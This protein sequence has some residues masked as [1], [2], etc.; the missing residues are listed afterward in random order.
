MSYANHISRTPVASRI[1]PVVV[2]CLHVVVLGAILWGRFLK[3][4]PLKPQPPSMK[5]E[6]V[7][8]K[9]LD[10]PGPVSPPIEIEK[11]K[12]EIEKPKAEIEKPKAEI[13][14]PKVEI[15][16]PKAEIKKPKAEI[17][18]PKVEIKKPKKKWTLAKVEDI[19]QRPDF[20]Q[21]KSRP[22]TPVVDVDQLTRK[23]R[24]AAGGVRINSPVS[25]PN[26]GPAETIQQDKFDAAAMRVVAARWSDSFSASELTGS[27][28]RVVVR[29]T[30]RSDGSVISKR[31]VRRSGVPAI[32]RRAA[33]LLKAI[34]RFSAPTAF[35][36]RSATYDITCD[37]E[38][39]E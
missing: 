17:K 24:K 3:L 31:I 15:K 25:R 11:P 18:K 21:V 33:G 36:I 16:K 37:L 2:V 10:D 5:V 39:A 4:E 34:T 29:F 26:R 30:I 27:G 9:A 13:E 8:A 14:K 1:I 38:A 32:D 35:G 22:R 7:F 12:V 6:L 19:R 23:F 28:R 20:Q